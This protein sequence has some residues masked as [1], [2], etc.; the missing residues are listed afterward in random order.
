MSNV[1]VLTD[2]DFQ[3]KTSGEEKP[4]LVDFWAPWCGPCQILGPIIEQLSDEHSDKA[5]FYKMDVDENPN[6]AGTFKIMSIPTVMIFKGG[7]VK[8]T[9][10]G[11][12]SKDVYLD[13]LQKHA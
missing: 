13:A 9:F 12:Q 6:T 1:A 7:E 5:D 4:V 3:E 11:V 8:E 2:T 10:I